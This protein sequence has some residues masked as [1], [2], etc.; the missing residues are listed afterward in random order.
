[1]RGGRHLRAELQEAW[2]RKLYAWWHHYNTEFLGGALKAPIIEL[3]E[4]RHRL[5]LWDGE[6]RRII[7]AGHH[8]E[9]DPWTAVMD[10]LRHE[11]AHQFAFEVWR[12]EGEPQHGEAFRR[13]C[14]RL[15]CE[16]RACAPREGGRDEDERLLRVLK[17][18]LSL[19]DSPNENEAQA[20]VNKARRLLLDYNLDIVAL[21]RQRQFEERS[22]GAV[23]GRRASWELWLAMILNEYFFVEVLWARTYDAH[24]D[25]DGSVLRVFGTPANLDMATYVYEYLSGLLPRLWAS[26]RERAG[27][28]G[29]GERLRYWAGVMQGFH[30]KLGE[31]AMRLAS[32]RLA[33]GSGALVWKGDPRLH[34]YYRHR[35][36][37]VEMRRTT[38]V[39]ASE[40]YRDGV[41]DGRKVSIRRPLTE[42]KEAFGG[43]LT[44]GPGES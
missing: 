24:R 42:S 25:R 34:D 36:P 2:T 8:V 40:A 31:Q 38:G 43:H 1:V 9:A 20:A 32:G 35:N 22:L 19:A 10:T 23:K 17:K 7:I 41:D 18:V 27:L 3:G 15:R 14:L 11:M 21:D 29:N 28:T 5:G 12:A 4:A 39:R 30:A 16:P 33:S 26:Y 44:A 13:A 37:R 6:R